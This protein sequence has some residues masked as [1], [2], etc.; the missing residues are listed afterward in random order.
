MWI[1]VN[2]LAE[3]YIFSIS[4]WLFLLPIFSTLRYGHIILGLNLEIPLL[5]S[6][7]LQGLDNFMHTVTEQCPGNILYVQ[8]SR[9]QMRKLG[10]LIYL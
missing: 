5:S 2:G 8:W 4:S 6:S 7:G 3:Y 9:W 1:K 10:S